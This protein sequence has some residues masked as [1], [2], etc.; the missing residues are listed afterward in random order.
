MICGG[1]FAFRTGEGSRGDVAAAAVHRDGWW[2]VVLRR[3]LDTGNADDSVLVPGGTAHIAVAVF[4]DTGA[5]EG[6]EHAKS[7]PI[8]LTLE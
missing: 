2:T 3:R 8:A 1:F 5:K 7:G 6:N 4:D